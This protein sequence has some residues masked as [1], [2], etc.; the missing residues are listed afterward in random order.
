MCSTFPCSRMTSTHLHLTMLPHNYAT[1]ATNHTCTMPTCSQCAR[2]LG[3]HVEH[4]M[5]DLQL[6]DV[7]NHHEECSEDGGSEGVVEKQTVLSEEHQDA[8]RPSKYSKLGIPQGVHEH[9]E[10][11]P[12]E[13]VEGHGRERLRV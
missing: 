9:L 1:P 10:D 13:E 12:V 8:Q 4:C 3:T 11:V 2:D 6:H 7:H 5:Q